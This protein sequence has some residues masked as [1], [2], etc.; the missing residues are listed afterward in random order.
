MSDFSD[1]IRQTL[2]VEQF[3]KNG[4]KSVSSIA[5]ELGTSDNTS[6][7]LLSRMKKR[8]SI[9]NVGTGMWGLALR[10]DISS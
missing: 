4:A 3:L 2:I 10:E 6:R 7:V 9:V 1:R 5:R 8:G